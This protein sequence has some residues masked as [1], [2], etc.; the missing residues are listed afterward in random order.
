MRVETVWTVEIVMSGCKPLVVIAIWYVTVISCRQVRRI[1][2]GVMITDKAS[3]YAVVLLTCAAY[4]CSPNHTDHLVRNSILLCF[5]SLR[6][7]LIAGLSP[8][9]TGFDFRR[10]CVCDLW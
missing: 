5:C 8:L 10:V 9:G 4:C 1:L 6:K 2:K 7:R 3:G